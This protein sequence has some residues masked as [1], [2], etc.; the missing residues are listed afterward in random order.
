MEFFVCNV[1]IEDDKWYCCFLMFFIFIGFMFGEVVLIKGCR[2]FG[3]F[4]G[5][6]MGFFV[7]IVV[8]EEGKW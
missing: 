8:I 6:I 4:K 1:V 2:L 5:V 7:C 3:L